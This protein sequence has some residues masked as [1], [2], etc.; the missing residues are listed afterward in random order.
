MVLTIAQQRPSRDWGRSIISTGS[1]RLAGDGGYGAGQKQCKWLVELAV[2]LGILTGAAE[3]INK[4][5][6]LFASQAAGSGQRAGF[7]AG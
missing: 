2:I 3:T 7:N 1:S 4:H 5:D 6:K